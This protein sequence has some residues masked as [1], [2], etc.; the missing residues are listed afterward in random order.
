MAP[1]ECLLNALSIKSG[2][3]I[4]M[5]G[6]KEEDIAEASVVPPK[7]EKG[8]KCKSYDSEEFDE[9]RVDKM[10]IHLA[11][12]QN[13]V[14]NYEVNLIISNKMYVICVCIY[15]ELIKSFFFID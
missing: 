9:E 14:D 15:N 13:R 4:M 3:K 6:S 2:T 5:V 1:D 7:R 10:E 8:R 12:V 11:K